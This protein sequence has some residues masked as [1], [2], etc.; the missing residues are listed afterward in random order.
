MSLE[1][2][3]AVGLSPTRPVERIAPAGVAPDFR[4]PAETPTDAARRATG[5]EEAARALNSELEPYAV[6]LEFSRDDETGATVVRVVDQRTGDLLRQIPQEALLRLSAALGEL[7]G[8]I[9]DREA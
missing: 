6:A 4:P 5:L 7:Q 8:M 1:T 2:T 9:F 3:G